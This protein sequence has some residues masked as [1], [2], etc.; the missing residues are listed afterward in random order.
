MRPG[1]YVI[2]ETDRDVRVWRVTGVFHGGTDGESVV[3]L[4]ACDRSKP[5]AYANTVHEMFVPVDLVA[6][7]VLSKAEAR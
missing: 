1:D 5:S 4:V 6:G 3:G 2:K 7:F